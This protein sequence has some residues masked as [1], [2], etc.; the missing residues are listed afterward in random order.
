MIIS[1]TKTGGGYLHGIGYRFLGQGRTG[2]VNVRTWTGRPTFF[3][4]DLEIHGTGT[5]NMD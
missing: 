3:G 4:R 1:G 2:K 5:G